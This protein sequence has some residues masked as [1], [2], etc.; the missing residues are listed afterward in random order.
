MLDVCLHLDV[1]AGYIREISP[2]D[3]YGV[4]LDEE[5]GNKPEV[6][7]RETILQ[8]AVIDLKPRKI[9]QLTPGSRYS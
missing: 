2:P 8:D 4:V 6:F 5:R 9:D 3:V 1:L 7:A